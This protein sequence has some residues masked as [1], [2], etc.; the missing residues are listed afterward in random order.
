MFCAERV[1][2]EP[3]MFEGRADHTRVFWPVYEV[4]DVS[5][6]SDLSL[7]YLT[8]N[9]IHGVVEFLTLIGEVYGH[10]LE[11]RRSLDRILEIY[12]EFAALELVFIDLAVLGL[13]SLSLSGW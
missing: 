4:R 5:V 10:I 9:S 3:T 1:Y 2:N 7:G 13:N 12:I 8:Y 11:F 6:T